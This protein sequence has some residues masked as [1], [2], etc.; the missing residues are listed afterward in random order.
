MRQNVEIIGAVVGLLALFAVAGVWT[1][2]A[3]ND[4]RSTGMSG[5]TCFRMIQR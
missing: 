3:Y 5:L 1:V 2:S 4:C